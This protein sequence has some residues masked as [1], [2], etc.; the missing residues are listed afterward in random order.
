ML[1][2]YVAPGPG[3]QDI[4]QL[5]LEAGF[6]VVAHEPQLASD[7]DVLVL[8]GGTDVHPYIY[9][10]HKEYGAAYD[11][12]RDIKEKHRIDVAVENDIPVIGI[13]RG[14]QLLCVYHGGKL[15]QDVKGHGNNHTAYG[16]APT[17]GWRP[18][19][20]Y[21]VTINSTHHQVAIPNDAKGVVLLWAKCGFDHSVYDAHGLP[22]EITDEVN[23]Y[24]TEYQRDAEVVWYPE[25]NHLGI[26]Y[27]PEWMEVGSKGRNLA[28]HLI[29][30]VANKQ[31]AYL[32]SD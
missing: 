27:H 22:V 1:K 17:G 15:Y 19:Q 5:M 11:I 9:A 13:C 28:I 20:P 32:P 10:H 29:K 21:Q 12:E 16:I 26:Q 23:A 3:K 31:Q 14:S 4:E 18:S 24:G 30:Q 7:L 8:C 2:A 25:H 6:S